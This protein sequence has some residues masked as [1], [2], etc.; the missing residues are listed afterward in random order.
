MTAPVDLSDATPAH[1]RRSVAVGATAALA[2]TSALACGVCCV[3][4]LALP[5]AILAVSG[6]FIAWFASLATVLTP[7]AI[8][9]VVAA[10]AWVGVQTYRTR[11]RPARSTVVIMAAATVMLV[12]AVTWPRY[13]AVIFHLIRR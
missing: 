7:I 5:A 1:R 9:A 8:F 2:A 3:L 12:A 13:E 10:W 4:P 11:R 6:G